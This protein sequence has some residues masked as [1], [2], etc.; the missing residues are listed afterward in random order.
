MG[1]AACHIDADAWQCREKRT[2]AAGNRVLQRLT[3]A[4]SAAS[5]L[6]A[7]SAPL[8]PIQQL[9]CIT[10]QVGLRCLRQLCNTSRRQGLRRR[11]RRDPADAEVGHVNADFIAMNSRTLRPVTTILQNVVSDYAFV[12]AA[13][14]LKH[15]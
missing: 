4:V 10:W 14:P 8:L 1:C 13:S 15:Y 11:E 12:Y 3:T 6:A 2:L 9:C 5:T 7:P